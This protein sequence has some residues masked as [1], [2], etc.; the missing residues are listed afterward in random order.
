VVAVPPYGSI[1]PDN[2]WLSILPRWQQLVNNLEEPCRWHRRKA[3]KANSA[4]D[5]ISL[6][7][8]RQILQIANPELLR[9]TECCDI[10]VSE[11][12]QEFAGFT[13]QLGG[14]TQS[15]GNCWPAGCQPGHNF[16]AQKIPIETGI[17]I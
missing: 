6:A 15:I 8:G 12:V 3:T 13:N 10:N 4:P 11:I 17:G 1:R 14:S 5:D 7:R 16:V 2:E 9:H